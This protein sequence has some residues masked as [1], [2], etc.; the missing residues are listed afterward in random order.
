MNTNNRSAIAGGILL[1]LLGI[2]LFARQVIVIPWPAIGW[3]FI[4]VGVGLAFYIGMLL[5]GRSTSGLAIPATILTGLGLIF[6]W[7]QYLRLPFEWSYGWTFI[8]IFIGLGI[9]INGL[10]AGELET[11]K[12][13]LRVMGIGAVLLLVFGAFMGLFDSLLE[14]FNF[15]PNLVPAGLFFLLGLIVIGIRL[16]RHFTQPAG[17]RGRLSLFWPILFTGLTGLWLLSAAGIAPAEQFRHA[18]SLWPLL[19]VALGLNL[20]FGSRNSWL[21]IVLAI[22]LVVVAAL[23]TFNLIPSLTN[24]LQNWD[25]GRMPG[26]TSWGISLGTGKQVSEERETQPFDGIVLD[27]LGSLKITQGTEQA[28]EIRASADLLPYLQSEVRDGML[29]LGV[30]PGVVISPISR[31]EYIV[32]VEKLK[33]L[34]ISGAVAVDISGLETPELVL[35]S[36]GTGSIDLTGLVAERVTT[37]ISGAG[38]VELKGK[39]KDLIVDLSGTGSLDA[40]DLTSETCTVHLSGVGSAKVNVSKEL[41]AEV[42]GVGSVRYLGDPTVT[43]DV[44]GMGSVKP[45]RDR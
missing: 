5:G 43:K 1:V 10:A 35:K 32:T 41:H 40:Y 39:T 23:A 17:E 27:S 28:L 9:F 19:L 37:E 21:N 33:Y 14:A 18:F 13:G 29:Q 34:Q 11:R 38:S 31:I 45:K 44:S 20:I 22:L 42:S 25:T 24:P 8:L 7:D 15:S 16:V 36:S 30:K 6:F 26:A 3:P 4:L 12:S 2:Y